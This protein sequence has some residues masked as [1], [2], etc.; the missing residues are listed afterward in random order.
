MSANNEENRGVLDRVGDFLRGDR[1]G[2]DWRWYAASVPLTSAMNLGNFGYGRIVQHRKFTWPGGEFNPSRSAL[3]DKVKAMVPADVKLKEGPSN[4]FD[5]KNRNIWLTKNSPSILA[6][7][8]GHSFQRPKLLRGSG[9]LANIVTPFS[10]GGSLLASD[11]DTSRNVALAG[12]AASAPLALV[13]LDASRRGYK[14]L[15]SAGAGRMR[16]LGSFVGV[17]SYLKS[18]MIPYLS[19]RVK[20]SMGGFDYA[21]RP[22]V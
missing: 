1:K 15:R 17:P 11:K 18:A 3:F 5:Y 22:G 21:K 16:S 14:L 12:A 9:L 2:L 20:D 7:E 13:E 4:A 19:H 10:T 6:H 8:I